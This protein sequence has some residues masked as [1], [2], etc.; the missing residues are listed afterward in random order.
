MISTSFQSLDDVLKEFDLTMGLEVH[1]QVDTKTK[2][3]CFCPISV[4]QA[5]ENHYVCEICSGHPGTLPVLNE[6]V[7]NKAIR[8]GLAL[9]GKIAPKINFDRKNY[10]YP[11]LPKGYQITQFKNPIVFD[12]KM[13]WDHTD[14]KKIIRIERI[15]IEEDTGKSTHHQDYSLLNYNRCGTPLLEIITAPDF[16]HPDDAVVYLK[17]LHAILKH[18]HICRGNLQ[19]GNFRCDVNVSLSP[20]G[21]TKLGT[22]CEVKNLNSFKNVEKS[23]IYESIRQANLLKSRGKVLQETRLFNMQEGK[24]YL[25]RTKSD[26]DDYRYFP[27]PDLPS[28]FIASSKVKDILSQLPELPDQIKNRLQSDYGLNHYDASLISQSF[29]I[30]HYFEECVRNSSDPKNYAKKIANWILTELF[31][32]LNEYNKEINDSPVRPKELVEL[33]S[34]LESGKISHKQ[35]KEVFAE[36]FDL[37]KSPSEIIA[38]KGFEQTS[39]EGELKSILEKLILNHPKE[40]E[41][42]KSGNARM[43][44]FFIGQVMKQTGG[45]ANAQLATELL[46]KLIDQQ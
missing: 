14:S 2:V 10:F 24:T 8:L 9:E 39:D 35:A 40:L 23:I 36:M 7:L 12:A 13:E 43:V 32:F 20:K 41:G 44:G 37:K 22:R 15:Q 1:A 19:D 27:E 26:A 30:V 42:I 38:S 5:Y 33:I 46:K 6:E 28:I 21:A 17:K 4:G 25:L 45:K 31:R 16:H 3:W 11:D 18:L 29:D 34:I